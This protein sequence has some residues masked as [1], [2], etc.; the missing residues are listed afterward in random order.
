MG[1]KSKQNP[2]IMVFASS[3][4]DCQVFKAKQNKN[5]GRSGGSKG[6]ILA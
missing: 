2:A 4:I 5:T 6:G 3:G 1:F